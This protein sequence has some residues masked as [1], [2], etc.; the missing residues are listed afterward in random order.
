[1]SIDIATYLTPASRAYYDK[2]LAIITHLETAINSV[3]AEHQ[4]GATS[5]KAGDED[6]PDY[7]ISQA[8]YPFAIYSRETNDNHNN[9]DIYIFGGFLRNIMEHH[10][11]SAREFTPPK[12]VDIFIRFD[13][14]H[15]PTPS[16]TTWWQRFVPFFISTLS[17]K[18]KVCKLPAKHN[19][20][21]DYDYC[22]TSLIVD[23][24]KFDITSHINDFHGKC[25]R[26]EEL[27]D[28]TVNNL[29]LDTSG[30]LQTRVKLDDYDLAISLEHIRIRQLVF[31]N[32]EKVYKWLIGMYNDEECKAA[33]DEYMSA[34]K[35]KM[36]SYGYTF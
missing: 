36:L 11:S 32:N 21:S 16:Q 13:E 17:Q 22:L 28:Y 6:W 2:V 4:P 23:D 9:A 29:M 27:T 33:Y 12:D 14:L 3:K 10:H 5:E 19:S 30:K 31:I 18:Y 26:F 25:P 8:K 20:Y 24:I 34:R 35:T 1:M 15:V 7:I